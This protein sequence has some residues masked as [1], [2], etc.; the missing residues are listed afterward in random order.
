VGHTG[1]PKL[2]GTGR[3]RRLEAL[4]LLACGRTP[5]EVAS[6]L[7]IAD[8]TMRRWGASPDFRDALAAVQLEAIREARGVLQGLVRE[9]VTALRD[10]LGA[11]VQPA[12]RLGAARD[13]LDRA[14]LAPRADVE[15]SDEVA[16]F[17]GGTVRIG[18]RLFRAVDAEDA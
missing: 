1:R 18:D 5:S 9:A 6:R 10:L 11:D 4:A 16:L 14:G 8:R 12:V 13:V 2:A 7:G 15:D 3:K 17:E